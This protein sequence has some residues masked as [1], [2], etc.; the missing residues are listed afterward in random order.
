MPAK[1]LIQIEERDRKSFTRV[2]TYLLI[3]MQLRVVSKLSAVQLL[4]RVLKCAVELVEGMD[5]AALVELDHGTQIIYLQQRGKAIITCSL[6]KLP[7]M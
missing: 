5:I 3:Y 2:V 4:Q 1:L 6:S 7:D